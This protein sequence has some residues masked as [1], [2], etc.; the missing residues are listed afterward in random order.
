MG[1]MERF[2]SSSDSS[3]MQFVMVL[4]IV[5]F[6]MMF[7]TTRGD[8]TGVAAEVN[9]V[10]IMHTDYVRFYRDAQRRA[11][12]MEQRTL[13]NDEQQ[14][15]GELVKQQLI[16]QEIEKQE[17]DRLGLF[18]SVAQV[19]DAIYNEPGFRNPEGEYEPQRYKT[20]LKRRQYTADE[21]EDQIR[22]DLRRN[23]LRQLVSMGA[24]VSEPV[25]R[26]SYV[27]R[28]T[29]M[30]L[31]HVRIR[32]SNFV[33]DIELDDA[34]ITEWMGENEA[35]VQETYDQ[36]LETRFTHPEG[37]GLAMINLTVSDD[38]ALDVI[39]AEL[40]TRRDEIEQGADFGEVAKA[41]SADPTGAT[42]GDLGVRAVNQLTPE[43][44]EAIEGLDVGGMSPVLVVEGR[45]VRLY[46]V[47]ERVPAKV[48]AF[49][50]V[51]V[52]IATQVIRDERLP[53][54][55]VQF[56]E[57]ELLESW[58]TSGEVPETLLAERGLFAL[59]T[60]LIPQMGVGDFP[61]DMLAAA[62]AAEPGEVL[63][64]VYEQDGEYWVAKLEEREKPDMELYES[65][66]EQIQ[67]QLL[68]E[69]RQAFYE[70]WLEDTKARSTIR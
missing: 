4:V 64:E 16:I 8:Q 45:E 47:V 25:V 5:S 54:R 18:V 3:G 55:T 44:A 48:D 24:S 7:G 27:E 46:K 69:R 13:S 49:E 33:D 14:N 53:E 56:A 11:E 36:A 10:K 38:E 32:Q 17:A 35:L 2:R 39:R 70:G 41:H 62:R 43:V 51:K 30:R 67:Q 28:S 22:Q 20:F 6:I 15:L 23:K 26:Q 63:P 9:G 58:K 66:K 57:G 19:A 61:E 50:D 65:N 34:A 21:F 31:S 59:D 37:V 60:G 29:R 40:A 12:G 68:Q 1:V 42:G 52:A